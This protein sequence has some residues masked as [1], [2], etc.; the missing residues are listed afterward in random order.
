MHDS[1]VV[2]KNAIA[3]TKNIADNRISAGM[4]MF[5]TLI[6]SKTDLSI[7]ED[8]K[9]AWDEECNRLRSVTRK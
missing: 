8:T 5:S 3:V 9:A 7:N 6:Y 2:Q 4:G 1:H